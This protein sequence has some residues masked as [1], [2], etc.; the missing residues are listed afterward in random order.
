MPWIER[1]D[2]YYIRPVWLIK[3]KY[4]TE[5]TLDRPGEGNRP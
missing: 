1:K 5:P 3:M 2:R 4:I